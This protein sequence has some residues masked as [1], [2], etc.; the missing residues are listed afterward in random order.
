[1]NFH[2]VGMA[3]CVDCLSDSYLLKTDTAAGIY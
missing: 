3:G 1:M 2:T